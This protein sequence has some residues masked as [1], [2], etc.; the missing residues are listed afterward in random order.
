MTSW[1]GECVAVLIRARRRELQ[2]SLSRLAERVGCAKSYL[3]EVETQRRRTPT[4]EMLARLEQA[5]M[6]PAGRLVSVARWQRSLEAG[7]EG[8][9]EEVARL[10]EDQRVARR[11]AELLKR[12]SAGKSLDEAYRSGELKALVNQLAPEEAELAGAM[13]GAGHEGMNL[14]ARP[15]SATAGLRAGAPAGAGGP[16]PVALAREVPLINKV[17]AGYPREFT[18]LAYPARVADEYVRCPDLE[19]ADAFAARVVGDSM[20]PLYA[21]GDIVIFSPAKVVKSGMDCFARLEPDHET[22][23]KRVYL[24]KGKDGEEMIR[25]QPLNAAYPPRVVGREEVAGLYAAV[26]VMR[27][28]VQ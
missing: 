28:V 10:T 21:E 1:D 26:S 16:I 22:T 12:G 27:K 3:S 19:D 8:V 7:G 2:L 24:E 14:P 15:R 6:M 25:L 13:N 23:F 18:D 20:Q 5:L 11:L 4:D 9:R 17:A